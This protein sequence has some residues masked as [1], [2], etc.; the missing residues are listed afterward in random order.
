MT[1]ADRILIVLVA[2]AAIASIPLVTL[3]TGGKASQVLA[4]S[5]AGTS[6]ISLEK[7]GRYRIQGR[8]GVLTLSVSEGRV[9]CV[10]ADCPDQ[11]CVRTGTAAAGR[12]IVCAP[13][14]VSVSLEG[15]VSEDLDAVSR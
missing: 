3:A 15:K 5:P 4:H 7:D 12:P 8:G 11:V 2:A 13:N 10:Q 9:R 6:V 14:G 1:R